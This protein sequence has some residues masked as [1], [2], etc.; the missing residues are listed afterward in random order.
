MNKIHY[1]PN[2]LITR[3]EKAIFHIHGAGGTGSHFAKHLSRMIYTMLSIDLDMIKH[4]HI[5]DYDTI[6]ENTAARANYSPLHKGLYKSEVLALSLNR[7][8][9]YDFFTGHNT[10]IMDINM[11]EESKTEAVLFVVTCTDSISSRRKILDYYS[12]LRI[13]FYWLD[14]GNSVN[15]SQFVLGNLSCFTGNIEIFKQPEDN[16]FKAVIKLKTVDRIFPGYF[17]VKEEAN[18]DSCSVADALSRQDMFINS[19]TAEYAVKMIYEFFRNYNLM[20]HGMFINL[21]QNSINPIMI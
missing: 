12:K 11:D 2:R 17:N 5:F 3:T 4:V 9:Q 16:Q 10:T 14:I 1:L 20:Y 15:T 7:F 6:D 13:P 19:I 8:Y 18:I 21:E